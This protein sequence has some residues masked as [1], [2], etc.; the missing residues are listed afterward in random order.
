MKHKSPD[1]ATLEPADRHKAPSYPD[2]DRQL[3]FDKNSSLYLS[4][5]D[6]VLDQPVHLKISDMALQQ[7]SERGV[8]G[9]PS[10]CYC[11][12]GVYEW[13]TRSGQAR[14]TISAQNCLHCKTCDIKD[15]NQNI[16]WTAPEGGDGPNYTNM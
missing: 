16:V 9:G 4:G 13:G 8:F 5:T 6:H 2:V 14:L 10:A 11:P 15:P 7:S 3:V 1:Y 12:A